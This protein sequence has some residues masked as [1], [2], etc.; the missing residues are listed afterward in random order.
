MTI[1]ERLT[2]HADKPVLFLPFLGEY[3][4][5]WSWFIR[6]V[7]FHPSKDKVVCCRKG[8]EI[9]FPSASGHFTDWTD[10]IPDCEKVA[11]I[12]GSFLKR[13]K[14]ITDQFPNHTPLE[15]GNLTHDEIINLSIHPETQIPFPW[16]KWYYESTETN[17]P[18][19]RILLCPRA[20][21][22]F[23][24][25]NWPLKRWQMI[26]DELTKRDIPFATLGGPNG[27]HLK[28]ELYMTGDYGTDYT[29]AAINRAQL[30]VT[31]DS[32]SAHM[33]A[34]IGIPMVIFRFDNGMHHNMIPMIERLNHYK[35]IEIT[36]G[37]NYPANV[38]EETLANYYLIR[39]LGKE[40]FRK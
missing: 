3:G 34:G 24:E 7:A 31:T 37:W 33:L 2:A 8:D 14:F 4:W 40:A 10:P 28:G 11:T 23:P 20:R 15:S 39:A 35:T 6:W 36:E 22:I 32:G 26:A 18:A 1:E 12:K 21:T 19:P 27:V 29:I 16:K 9:Q 5:Y 38:L 25:K 13:W 30:A 17:T